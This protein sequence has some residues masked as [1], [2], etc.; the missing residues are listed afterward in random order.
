MHGKDII[1]AYLHMVRLVQENLIVWLVMELT[2]EL[3]Q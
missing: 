3:C 2:K 1:V